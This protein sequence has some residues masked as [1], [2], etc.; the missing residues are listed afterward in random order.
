MVY[1]QS[2]PLNCD[3]N[4]RPGNRTAAGKIQGRFFKAVVLPSKPDLFCSRFGRRYCLDCD[5]FTAVFEGQT[6]RT[7]GQS[8]AR[9][10]IQRV[11]YINRVGGSVNESDGHCD[12]VITSFLGRF[13]ICYNG[14]RLAN[15][16]LIL[17]GN[18]GGESRGGGHYNGSG[19]QDADHRTFFECHT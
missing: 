16:G 9:Y 15:S 17:L 6:D 5:D 13:V 7:V 4:R 8:L 2:R 14:C 19:H 12:A 10:D 18:I 11:F 1:W 3:K